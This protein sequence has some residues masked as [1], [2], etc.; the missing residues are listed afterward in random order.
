V[1]KDNPYIYERLAGMQKILMGVH[2]ASSPMS[3]AAKGSER[4]AFI[5]QFLGEVF[6][7]MFRFGTGDATDAQGNKSGQLDVVIEYPFAP[8]LPAVGMAKS[9]LYLAEG[10]AAVLEIKSNVASQWDEVVSTAE[11]LAPLRK[12]LFAHSYVGT[13]P[14]EQI[15]F[16]A[17]GYTGWKDIETVKEKITMTPG[18]SGILVIDPGIFVT[19]DKYWGMGA[20][21]PWALWLLISTLHVVTSSLK[22][23]SMDPFQYVGEEKAGDR[24][25]SLD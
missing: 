2:Q 13:P 11:K 3:S 25:T 10:I 22:S 9:R 1:N 6:P 4:A 15:P 16:F 23:A 12:K 18:I 24:E 17:V 8:S 5:D 7:T 21:G 14:F 19:G 20:V